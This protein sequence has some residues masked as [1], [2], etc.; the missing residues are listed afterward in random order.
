MLKSAVR[1]TIWIA[2]ILAL[3]TALIGVTPT[4]AGEFVRGLWSGFLQF[5]RTVTGKSA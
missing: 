1:T 2:I 5:V 4:D 3:L